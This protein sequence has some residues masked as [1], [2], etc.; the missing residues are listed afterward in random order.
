MGALYILAMLS[1]V[2]QNYY[3]KKALTIGQDEALFCSGKCQQWIHHYYVSVS[4][5]C[6]KDIKKNDASFFC[7]CCNEG[8]GQHEI[9]MLKS[10]VELLQQEISKLN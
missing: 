5:A 1:S 2:L 6:Y 4:V 10:T 8:K 9:A 7:F 3:L